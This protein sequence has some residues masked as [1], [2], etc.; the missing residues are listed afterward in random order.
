MGFSPAIWALLG[1]ILVLALLHVSLHFALVK[2]KQRIK[3]L[4]ENRR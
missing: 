4:E 1:C 3:D 2:L